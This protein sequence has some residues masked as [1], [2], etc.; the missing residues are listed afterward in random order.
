MIAGTDNA[1]VSASFGAC[2]RYVLKHRMDHGHWLNPTDKTPGPD[3]SF[4]HTF[5]KTS[6]V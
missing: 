5:S 3:K 6:L 1:R 4:K 2:S